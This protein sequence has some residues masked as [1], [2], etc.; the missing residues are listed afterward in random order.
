MDMLLTIADVAR[1][2]QSCDRTIRR[3]IARGRLDVVRIGRSVRIKPAA[4]DAWL[5]R[6]A[7]AKAG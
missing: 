6:G 7:R 4:V 3:E 1:L 5:S 2:T